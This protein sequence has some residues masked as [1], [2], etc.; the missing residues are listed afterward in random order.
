MT[1]SAAA[2]LVRRFL[3]AVD[4]GTRGEVP[5]DAFAEYL[6]PEI[7]Q[8]E[9]PNKFAPRGAVRD[10]AAL[11][12]NAG[13]GRKLM[14]SQRY[15]ID[16][17]IAQGDTVAAFGRWTGVLAIPLGELRAGHELVAHLAMRFELRDGRIYRQYNYD[18]FDP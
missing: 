18:C 17:V 5:L 15:E 6:H 3:A 13:A 10:L 11:R 16:T 7:E 12:A 1:D 2:A 8:R 14:R 9:L 4:A